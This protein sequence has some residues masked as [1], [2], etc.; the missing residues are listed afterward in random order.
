MKLYTLIFFLVCNQVT[1][2]TINDTSYFKTDR[3]EKF[4]GVWCYK[5]DSS[6]FT[7]KLIKV[8]HYYSKSNDYDDVIHGWHEYIKNGKVIESSY[9]KINTRGDD[10]THTLIGVPYKRDT[11]TS[12][13]FNVGKTQFGKVFLIFS[14]N[15]HNKL[16]WEL[17]WDEQIVITLQGEPK[18][19]YS[20]RV[21]LLL[22]LTRQKE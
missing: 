8:K 7:I 13:Y 20:F 6:S 22:E 10:T 3:L 21:P 9:S 16:R 14:K 11:L 4:E 2:Q 19:D 15:D 5:D 1:G 17:G 18:Q 12:H